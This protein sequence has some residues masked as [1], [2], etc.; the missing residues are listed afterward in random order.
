MTWYN[1]TGV[2]FLFQIKLVQF[3]WSKVYILE[4]MVNMPPTVIILN[5][6]L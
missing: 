1:L 5:H 2:L 6:V 4:G 3:K